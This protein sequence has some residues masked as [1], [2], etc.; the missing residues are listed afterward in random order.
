MMWLARLMDGEGRRAVAVCGAR[1]R[2]LLPLSLEVGASA[3]GGLSAVTTYRAAEFG[4]LPVIVTTDD[5]SCGLRGSVVDGLKA[6][7][8]HAGV[9]AAD[10][11]I[12]ACGP[13]KMLRAVADLAISE[14]IACQVCTERMMACGMGTCQ[15]CVIRIRDAASRE[16]WRYRLCCSD[17]PVFDAREVVW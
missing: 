17:G 13:E 6:A 12:Y 1:G 4:S 11:A 7:L 10:V 8:P 15:S 16:G 14:G 5:G 3:A 9:R 2:S